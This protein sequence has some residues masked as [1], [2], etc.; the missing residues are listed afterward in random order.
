ME[1]LVLD[2]SKKLKVIAFGG[3]GEL[4]YS[5]LATK[6]PSFRQLAVLNQEHVNHRKP[7]DH[8]FYNFGK[9]GLSVA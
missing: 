8:V 2:F 4:S 7:V 3:L 5:S 6:N 9:K 1:Y